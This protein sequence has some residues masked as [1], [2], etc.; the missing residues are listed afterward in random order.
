MWSEHGGVCAFRPDE[1]TSN[2]LV[3]GPLGLDQDLTEDVPFDDTH[4]RDLPFFK[5]VLVDDK[6][7]VAMGT[8]SVT[9]WTRMEE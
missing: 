3:I 7:P 4:I 5:F 6:V 2:V 9:I 8:G 1:A